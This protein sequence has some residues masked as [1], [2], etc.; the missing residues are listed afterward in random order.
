MFYRLTGLE[1]DP[2]CAEFETQSNHEGLLFPDCE[3]SHILLLV[4]PSHT[5]IHQIFLNTIDIEQTVKH[6]CLLMLPQFRGYF[7]NK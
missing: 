6:K 3:C 1:F 4:F 2:S 5:D 7:S